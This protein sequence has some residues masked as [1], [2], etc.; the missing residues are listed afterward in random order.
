MLSCFAFCVGNAL[1]AERQWRRT[2]TGSSFKTRKRVGNALN[3][4]RQ[5]RLELPSD[6]GFGGGDV[7]NALNAERQWRPPENLR[8]SYW[9]PESGTH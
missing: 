7:G 8:L 5:W 9:T 2:F 1:N 3:A 6:F 4:E